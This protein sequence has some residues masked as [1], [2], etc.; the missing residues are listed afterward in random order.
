MRQALVSFCVIALIVTTISAEDGDLDDL[1]NSLFTK[2]PQ[3]VGSS[4]SSTPPPAPPVGSMSSCQSGQRCIQKYLC[5]NA[6]TTGEGQIDIRFDDDNPCVDYLLQCCYEEDIIQEPPS[7]PTTKIPIDPVLIHPGCGKRNADGI[8]FRITGQKDSEAEYGEFPWM[9]AVLRQEN[10]LDQV[11]NVYLCGGSLIHPKVVLTA[12]HCLH[13]RTPAQ[14]KVRAGEWD[15]QTRNEIYPHQDRSVVEAISHPDY[16]KGGLYNDIA[17]LFLD[18]P[19]NL[20][21]GIQTVCLPPQ[22]TKFDQQRCLASGWGK[23]VFGKSG[24]YQVILKKIELPIV[25]PS[26]CQTALRTTRLGPKFTLHKSFICAGGEK[27]RDTC[28]GDG[29][30]PLVC[31]IQGSHMHYYQAGIVAWGI[32]CGENAIP[33]VYADV[34]NFRNWIDQQIQQRQLDPSS[35]SL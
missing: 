8:G 13:N 17:L 16:Y 20:D 21:E 31:P 35:Y 9:V 30:S 6:S 12:A 33:G 26:Q 22:G 25:T 10:A 4:V 15:T 29:G 14:L 7:P 2:A 23:D 1:I 5:T 34:S 28:K 3:D 19:F 11:V 27:G 32:G 18:S 24:T